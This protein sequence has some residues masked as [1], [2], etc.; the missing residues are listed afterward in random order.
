MFLAAAGAR[1][2]LTDLPHITPLTRKNVA[3]NCSSSRG[4]GAATATASAG[5]CAPG[6][7]LVVDYSWG[8]PRAVLFGRIASSPSAA[9][10]VGVAGAHGSLRGVECAGGAME[11]VEPE[12]GGLRCWGSGQEEFDMIV[13]AD[14]L[15]DPEV[16]GVLLKSL[17][18]LAAPHT[19]VTYVILFGAA[20]VPGW[21]RRWGLAAGVLLWV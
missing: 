16:H 10:A 9:A 18:E 20:C 8:E 21:F 3:T 17:G 7:P 4:A 14:L 5:C 12:A 13:G 19:Q 2:V 15:Y 11:R 6:A 1:V